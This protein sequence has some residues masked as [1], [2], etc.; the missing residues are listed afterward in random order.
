MAAL[1]LVLTALWHLLAF[2]HFALFPGRTLAL[3]TRERPVSEVATELLRFLGGLNL[4]PVALALTSLAM[5]PAQR[6]T[7]FLALAVANASQLVVDLR[8][9]RLGLA[10][11]PFFTQ[12]LVGDCFFTAANLLAL[13]LH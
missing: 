6:W 10:R 9:Q 3:T 12:I 4:A 2:W 7:A 8:V 5:A 11:G 13:A 1:I